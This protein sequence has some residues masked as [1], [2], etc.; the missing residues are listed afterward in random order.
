M[1]LY[2]KTGDAGQTGLIG[3]ARVSK[4]DVRVA[5][6]GEVDELNAAIGLVAAMLPAG[7][8]RD[9]LQEIQSDL[10]ILGAELATRTGVQPRL[11]IAGIHVERL[12]RLLDSTCAALP[13]LTNF[14]L[15]GGGELAARLHLAR[16]ICR[17]AER[18]VVGLARGVEL[19]SSALIYLNRLSDLLFALALAANRA[20]GV[21]DVIWRGS[22][23]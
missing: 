22:E 10:F 16:T 17:R 2:T 23:Q 18:A 20:A 21:A 3:G 8:Q 9:V 12:E 6:Y 1:K 14:V 19:N 11:A 5:C 4:D 13:E 15:P 7:P